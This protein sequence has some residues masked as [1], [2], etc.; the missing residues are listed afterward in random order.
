MAGARVYVERDSFSVS[1]R[2]DPQGRFRFARSVGWLD[3]VRAKQAGLAGRA[4]VQ[5]GPV[6]VHLEKEGALRVE[7]VSAGSGERVRG[8]EIAVAGGEERFQEVEP[9]LFVLEGPP[10]RL[11][12][13]K[14]QAPG[15][16]PESL[17]ATLTSE[18]RTMRV[19]LGRGE[20][21]RGIVL[22]EGGRPLA[23]AAVTN[24]PAIVMHSP[25]ARD[26]PSDATT[27]GEGRFA[28]AGLPKGGHLIEVSAAGHALL[29]V[30][31]TVPRDGE[32]VVRMRA[33]KPFVVEVVDDRGQAVPAAEV[34]VRGVA[35]Q[36]RC[37]AGGVTGDDG[38]ADLDACPPAAW[39]ILPRKQ[40]FADAPPV[41]FDSRKGAFVR[42]T[43]PRGLSISGR[44]VDDQGAPLDKVHVTCRRG[45]PGQ[46]DFAYTGTDPSGAFALTG[47]ADADYVVSAEALTR[48]FDDA[49]TVAR[50]GGKP[51]LLTLRRH[52]KE[53][54]AAARGAVTGRVVREGRPALSFTV[55]RTR[56]MAED[57]LHRF[58]SPDGR[59]LIEGLHPGKQELIVE[60]DFASRVIEVAVVGGRTA[61]AGDVV[62][63]AGGDVAGTVLD[64]AG[65]P[66]AGAQVRVSLQGALLS[67]DAATGPDGT[68][69]VSNVAP[70]PATAEASRHREAFYDTLEP[71]PITVAAGQ[72]TR[73]T[74]QFKEPGTLLVKVVDSAGRPAEDV[75][76]DASAISVSTD[77]AG[78]ADF[79]PLSP[80][81]YEVEAR[82]AF[83]DD[84]RPLSERLRVQLKPKEKR[85]VTL[86]LLRERAPRPRE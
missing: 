35:E 46:G 26:R 70:G 20:T 27:D 50:P 3:V 62:V 49:R 24:V 83:D 86:R 43:L 13:L 84:E 53:E 37:P 5:D 76:V 58:V 64:D 47:L 40:G 34:A 25:V 2:T 23:G 42:V 11:L 38:R 28:L 54:E 71:V 79:S 21:L 41:P 32:L 57:D 29:H 4:V 36:D 66:V 10:V 63:G 65:K 52:A 81:T 33:A 60:G 7:V 39:T 82:D 78:L 74:L 9:G 61:D 30:G 19:T 1:T 8:A 77:G 22:D 69:R 68:F 85:E 14:V 45:R 6:T 17:P 72:T 75:T 48:P 51:L 55:R 73:V 18:V 56:T 59:F 16:A 12:L 15:H 67:H 31:A 80:G 44:V